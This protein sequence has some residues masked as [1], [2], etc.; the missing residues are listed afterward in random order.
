MKNTASITNNIF[1][2]LIV[3]VEI[4]GVDKTIKSLQE[5]RAKILILEDLGIESIINAVVEVTG[6][7][8]D[9]ILHGTDRS[10][11][12]K[13]ALA[14]CIF[15]I[16]FEYKYSYSDIAKIFSKDKAGL[17]RY[18]SLVQNLS[19]KPK[20]EFDKRLSEY[21]KKLELFI[22]REKIK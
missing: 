16:K 12:R 14:L 15:Y 18:N 17:Y 9:R 19:A 7:T 11:D 10:D 1:D 4:I 2:E 5:A 13:I 3:T 6:V 20:N 21:C 22:T 8:K